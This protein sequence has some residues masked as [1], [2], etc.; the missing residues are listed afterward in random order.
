ML[1]KQFRLT[2][3]QNDNK[4]EKLKVSSNE[5]RTPCYFDV[6]GKE[7]REAYPSS[8]T[9]TSLSLILSSITVQMLTKESTKPKTDVLSLDVPHE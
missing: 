2:F 1:L 7:K 3:C 4:N 5:T 8:S 9:R 6:K